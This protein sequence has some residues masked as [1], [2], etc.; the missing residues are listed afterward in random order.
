MSRIGIIGGTGIYKMP[1]LEVLEEIEQPTPFG[2]PS[3]RF[4]LGRLEGREIVFLARHGQGHSLLPSE[5]NSR[6]NIYGM[7]KLGVSR[8]IS[9]SAVGSLK[10]DFKP[11]DLVLVDQF[12]DRTRGGQSQTFFGDGIAAHIQFSEPLCPQ[13]RKILFEAGRAIGASIKWGG[14]Y[15]NMEGPAFSTL[16]ESQTYRKWGMD[17]IGMTQIAEAKLA[18]EAEI[19]FATVAT[20]TDYDCW[21]GAETGE[22]VSVQVVIENL[23]RNVRVARELVRRAVAAIPQDHTCGCSDALDGAIITDREQWPEQTVAKLEPL[24]SKYL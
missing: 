1:G 24:L 19:C 11:L 3:D 12:V 4:R 15:L 22:T 13:L 16:A 14:T 8:I 10:K 7:K 17:V 9:L 21:Y 2:Q 5:L 23:N 20:V 18:R 6:A